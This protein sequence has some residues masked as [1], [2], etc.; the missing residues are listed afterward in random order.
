MGAAVVRDAP[1]G[2]YRQMRH[3]SV[4]SIA[5]VV[6]LAAA[7][8]CKRSSDP[9]TPL[10][11]AIDRVA[12]AEFA[13]EAESAPP[14]AVKP[15]SDQFKEIVGT[16]GSVLTGSCTADKWPESAISCMTAVTSMRELQSCDRYLSVDQ[17]ANVRR[18]MD[19]AMAGMPGVRK[20]AGMKDTGPVAAP[21]TTAGSAAAG[22]A[23]TR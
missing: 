12:R 17:K 21:G 11:P 13:R 7:S 4:V 3:G 2:H 22:S 1:H 8:A 9:C 20:K 15:N 16:V 19:A 18:A 14:E 10:A 6:W 23:A 5:L